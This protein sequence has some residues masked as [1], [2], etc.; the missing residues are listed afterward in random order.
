MKAI[1]NLLKLKMSSRQQKYETKK[2]YSLHSQLPFLCNA[3]KCLH[4]GLFLMRYLEFQINTSIS[5]GLV[6]IK[7]SAQK[8]PHLVLTGIGFQKSTGTIYSPNYKKYTN[9]IYKDI[10]IYYPSL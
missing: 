5:K 1:C 10:S 6:S 8:P 9:L 7:S 3:T 4:D 2:E